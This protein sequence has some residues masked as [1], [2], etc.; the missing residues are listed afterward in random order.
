[1]SKF[2]PKEFSILQPDPTITQANPV[3]NTWYTLLDTI[4]D[5]EIYSAAIMVGTANE[6]LEARITIND[7]V[8]P[9]SVAATFGTTYSV[10]L[11]HDYT[12]LYLAGTAGSVL[13]FLHTHSTLNCKTFKMEVRKTTANGTGTLYAGVSYGLWR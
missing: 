4:N 5:A 13:M 2:Y 3:Q 9:L 7:I 6:T 11:A 8:F 12:G 10:Y 1:M